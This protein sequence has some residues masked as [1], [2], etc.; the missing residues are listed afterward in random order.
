MV[1]VLIRL[2][3][4]QGRWFREPTWEPDGQANPRTV[5]NSL[6]SHLLNR[7]EVPGFSYSA[8]Y[9]NG[10]V[11]QV[12]RDWYCD[13]ATGNDLSRFSGWVPKMTRKASH[14]FRLA[15]KDDDAREWSRIV[16]KTGGEFKE[17]KEN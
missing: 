13:L 9:E 4:C 8:W 12:E 7:D 5:L 2:A 16:R 11:N 14:W 6:I 3:A 15:P 1:P 17:L 10:V